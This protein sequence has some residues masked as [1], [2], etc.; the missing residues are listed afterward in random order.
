MNLDED[1][2]TKNNDINSINKKDFN[3]DNED[4]KI[5]SPINNI[6]NY[7]KDNNDN[8]KINE[9]IDINLNDNSN[10]IQITINNKV[11]TSKIEKKNIINGQKEEKENKNQLEQKES[12]NK[13]QSSL[14]ANTK[15]K[16]VSKE[17]NE[18]DI[19]ESDYVI[20]IKTVDELVYYFVK[21]SEI[22]DEDFNYLIMKIAERRYIP[23]PD[24]QTVFDFMADIIIL[25]KMEKEVIILS[26][27]YIERLTFNTGI[28]VTSRNWRR[29]LLTAMIISSRIW[30]DSSFQN[31]HYSQVFANLGVSEI[32][33]LERTFLELINYK[34]YVKQSEYFRYLLMLKTIALKYNFDGKQII[35]VSVIKNMKYQEFTDAL[36]N[37]M[38]KKVTLNNSAQ[39]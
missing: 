13:D 25:T 6:D 15:N 18:E 28:L 22:F 5:I 14:S 38:R 36:Q 12:K 7:K 17:N 20:D 35:P 26:L 30:D 8:T 23:P 39:F 37:R 27:I 9:K 29:I 1:M 33:A 3:I 21:R 24:P 4:N 31:N 34:V 10:N 32:N 11:F 2:N 16:E 19:Y